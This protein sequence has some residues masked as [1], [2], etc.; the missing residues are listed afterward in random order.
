[1]KHMNIEERHKALETSILKHLGDGQINETDGARRFTEMFTI[2]EMDDDG[3]NLVHFFDDEE[4]GPVHIHPEIRQFLRKRDL[5]LM[6]L[7][8][9]DGIWHAEFMMGPYS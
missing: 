8:E 2:G 7:V 3:V 6:G 5:F 9:R 1:M 4:Y